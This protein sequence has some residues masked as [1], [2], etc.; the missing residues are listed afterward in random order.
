MRFLSLVFT[1]LLST[2]VLSA[3]K[4]EILNVFEKYRED[5][6]QE[7]RTKRPMYKDKSSEEIFSFRNCEPASRALAKYLRLE[8][9]QIEEVIAP[10]HYYLKHK[11]FIIDPTFRQ[12]Y[13][14]ALQELAKKNGQEIYSFDHRDFGNMPE[15]LIIESSKLKRTLENFPLQPEWLIKVGDED[16][17]FYPS[18]YEDWYLH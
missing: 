6:A 7:I 2:E 17:S 15:I 11:N 1:L 16:Y 8:R 12:F 13:G 14:I 4:Q 10:K 5:I 3:S 9:I 18:F